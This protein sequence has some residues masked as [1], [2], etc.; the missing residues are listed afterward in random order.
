[1][2]LCCAAGAQAALPGESALTREAQGHLLHGHP[3]T[4]LHLFEDAAAATGQAI[5]V[6]EWTHAQAAALGH[7]LSDL[8]RYPQARRV[9][10][11]HLAAKKAPTELVLLAAEVE[12]QIGL[13]PA[14]LQL[15]LRASAAAPKDVRLTVAV[16][17]QLIELGKVVQA[18]KILDPIADRYEAGELKEV[19]E[20]VAVA[21]SLALMGYVR[22]A[23]RVFEEAEAAAAEDSERIAVNLAWGQL[24]VSK[25][26]YR[27][28]DACFAKVLAIDPNHAAALLGMARVDLL[29]DHAVRA[30]HKRV[31]AVLARNPSDLEALALRAEIAMEDED[32]NAA[33]QTLARARQQRPDDPE[34]IRLQGAACKLADDEAGFKQAEKAMRQIRPDD[35]RFYLTAAIWLE[36]VHRYREVLDLLGQALAQD[37]DLWRAHAALGMGYARIADDKKAERELQTAYDGDRFDV[38]TANQLSVLYDGVLK[39]MVLLPGTHVD[40]RVHRKD[41]KAL[42]RTV[43]PFLQEA[44]DK[45]A[46]R[47]GFAPQRPLQV[48]IFPE[49]EQFSVRTVGL[50]H[51]GAHAV[52][53]GHLITSRS[54]TEKPFNWKM[55]LY[56]E[57]SH[58]FHIQASDGRVPRWLTEGLAMMEA[59]W[60][61]PRWKMNMDRRAYDR[62]KAGDL[63]QVSRFNLAFSQAQSMPEIV[64]AYY[65]SMLLVEFLEQRYGMPKLR[66]LVA[67]YR[68]GKDT[69]T[70][71][72]QHLG[73]EGAAIDAQFATWLGQKLA[74]YDRDFR[75]TPDALAKE[76]GAAHGPDLALRGQLIHAI[77]QLR[78]AK[79]R[80]ALVA[81]LALTKAP[82]APDAP[83]AERRDLCSA[84]F[85]L[86]DL[87]AKMGD[88]PLAKAQ[89]L[90]LVAEPEGRCDGVHQ[91]LLLAAALQT[92][93][94]VQGAVLHLRAASLIDPS[95]AAPAL[96]RMRALLQMGQRDAAR[97]AARAA[98]ELEAN[99]PAPAAALGELA[100]EALASATTETQASIA[101]DLELAARA[102][103]EGDPAGRAAPLYEAR[104]DVAQGHFAMALAAYRLAAERSTQAA[105]RAQAWCELQTAAQRAGARADRDEAERHCLAERPAAPSATPHR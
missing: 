22:D 10:G 25:S 66:D 74:R 24:F 17:E 26:N 93:G 38:R 55:V 85:V 70:L 51:L 60:A 19:D 95:D 33:L 16:G 47:Y 45:L 6:R 86:M 100:W 94:D 80:E 84:R 96:L 71:V 11:P 65:Q 103:E 105:E 53:F 4:A 68:S 56:H 44:H 79:G 67:G 31:D 46:Q 37:P 50:P 48:E 2:L 104:R 82:L 32:Y 41:R 62:W 30:A 13:G 91:R 101:Q 88:Q 1:M 78:A 73:Q 14:R 5:D 77:G 23:N 49:T 76:L 15:L 29:S 42:E 36:Q 34:L 97:A 3:E 43:L 12:R 75:P 52:C 58:V 59:A 72:R 69:A 87:A 81:L 28:G 98:T 18:R 61:D 27:D 54:P 7:A 21:R 39:Q 64:D 90:A 102:L 99:D 8:G 40:L 83:P 63:A 9:L 57:L 35:G 89:A 20:L 92:A